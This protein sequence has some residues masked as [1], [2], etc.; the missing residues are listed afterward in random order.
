MNG[1]IVRFH[2]HF[3]RLDVFALLVTI[4]IMYLLFTVYKFKSE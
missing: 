1:T 3:K 2:S 4:K